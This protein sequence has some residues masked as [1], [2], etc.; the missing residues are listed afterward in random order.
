MNTSKV[1]QDAI[2]HIAQELDLGCICFLNT[3]TLEVESLMMNLSDAYEDR[4]L[5]NQVDDIL[6]KVNSWEKSI[7][8]KPLNA[9]EYYKIM[10]HFV[11]RCI[12]DND[13]LKIRLRNALTDNKPFRN[14]KDIIK[15]SQYAQAWF[16]FK[17]SQLELY[18]IRVLR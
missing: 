18:V 12:P 2:K 9:L 3:E 14:F 15:S 13:S 11:E 8:I 7:K 1:S 17:Q 10:E 16:D 4:E 5:S 6:D